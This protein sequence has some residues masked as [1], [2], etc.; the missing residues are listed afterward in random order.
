MGEAFDNGSTLTGQATINVVDDASLIFENTTASLTG[1]W[2]VGANGLLDFGDSLESANSVAVDLSGGTIRGEQ[3]GFFNNTDQ[4][5]IRGFGRFELPVSNTTEITADGGELVIENDNYGFGHDNDWDGIFNNGRLRAEAGDLHLISYKDA[6]T[7]GDVRIGGGNKLEVSNFSVDFAGSVLL[8][9]GTVASEDLQVFSGNVDVTRLSTMDSFVS[10]QDGVEV[11]LA[12]DLFLKGHEAFH[13]SSASFAGVGKLFNESDNRLRAVTDSIFGVDVINRGTLSGE[14]AEAPGVITFAET[15]ENLGTIV[16]DLGGNEFGQY[17]HFD[18]LD[19]LLVEDGTFQVRLV[20]DFN[21]ILGDEYDF[22]D[23]NAFVDN[24][25]LFD[26]PELEQGLAW[27]SSDFVSQGI[28][29]I[30]AV[31]E[32]SAVSLLALTLLGLAATRRRQ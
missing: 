19:E 22:L 25:V 26:L 6:T 31:P 9:G 16:F 24:G 1:A 8:N 14:N 5:G 7:Q 30:N 15:L 11:N 28:L 29:R 4:Q 27:D 32:P 17:S 3:S 18:I 20:N 21:P 10:F 23:F 2:N 12:A 13:D